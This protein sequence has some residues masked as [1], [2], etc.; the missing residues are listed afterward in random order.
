MR[1][2][3]LCAGRVTQ[4]PAADTV[5][6]KT[7]DVIVCGLGNSGALAALFAAENGLSV[8]GIENLGAAG[9]TITLGGIPFHYFGCPGGRADA[10]EEARDDFGRRYDCEMAESGRFVLEEKHLPAG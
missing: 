9:G 10:V 7:W 5:F 3:E 6:E 4:R 8:L 1:L 2:S